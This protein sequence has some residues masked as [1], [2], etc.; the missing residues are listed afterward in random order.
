MII[1]I[2][3]NE[4]FNQGCWSLL[5]KRW[6]CS[7]D[8][9]DTLFTVEP[10][11]LLET[12]LPF[13]SRALDS[14]SLLSPLDAPSQSICDFLF[15][16][17]PQTLGSLGCCLLILLVLI[18]WAHLHLLASTTSVS[19]LQPKPILSF[20]QIADTLPGHPTDPSSPVYSNWPDCLPARPIPFGLW[21]ASPFVDFP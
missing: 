2:S 15:T 7:Y 18:R 10:S 11:W 13:A 21:K 8:L 4:W 12:W 20:S 17:A 14:I 1:N 9:C 3:T 19:Y 6:L 5:L 16:R